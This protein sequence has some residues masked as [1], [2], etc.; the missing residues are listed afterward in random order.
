[1]KWLVEEEEIVQK[2]VPLHFQQ[3]IFRPWSSFGSRV[4]LN[5]SAIP[6][7]VDGATFGVGS[8][9]RAARTRRVHAAG[10]ACDSAA[11]L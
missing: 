2:T 8:E 9:P 11:C 4:Q 6:A 7:G 3:T 10:C 5:F 1:M